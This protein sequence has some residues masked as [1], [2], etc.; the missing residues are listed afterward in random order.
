[1]GKIKSPGLLVILF[2]IL[3]VF[4]AFVKPKLVRTKVNDKISILVPDGWLPME[5]MDFVQRYPSVRAPLAAFTNEERDTD[6]SVNISAT[7]WPESD[8]T[9][10]QRFFKSSLLNM[11]DKVN[12]LSEGIHTVGKKQLIY[13][14]FESRIE[15]NKRKEGDQDPIRRYTYIQYL[16]EKD[17]T[18]VF[19][20][21]TP[22]RKR[23]EWQETAGKIMTSIKFK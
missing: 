11:F 23:E 14:E 10:P 17:K 7:Q 4:Q 5:G 6:L 8:L 16:V 19:S 12:I 1:M 22:A 2:G 20:F 21:S 9:V 3:L 13:F 18:L 15:G